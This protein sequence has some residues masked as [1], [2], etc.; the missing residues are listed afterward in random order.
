MTSKKHFVRITNRLLV[1]VLAIAFS[2]SA[3]A[4]TNDGGISTDMLKQIVKTNGNSPT[5]KAIFN[6]VAGNGIDNLARTYMSNAE[7]DTHFSVETP[8][9]NIHDQK[10]SGR[11]WM[12][13]GFNVLRSN[14]AKRTDSLRVEFA[15]DYLFF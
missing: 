13:S 1:P 9:Q 7:I 11:C 15:D 10:S 4:Q 3:M 12:F 14:F 6:A 2:H 8:A 5:D